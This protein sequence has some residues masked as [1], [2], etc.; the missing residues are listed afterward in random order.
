[1]GTA[2]SF[3]FKLKDADLIRTGYIVRD[4]VAAR[5]QSQKNIKQADF[6]RSNA[7]FQVPTK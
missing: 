3:V 1:M 4:A 5:I 7:Q 6:V 2:S